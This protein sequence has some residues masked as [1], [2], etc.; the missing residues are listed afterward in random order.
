M[1]VT[2]NPP[3]HRAFHSFRTD[4]L[5]IRTALPTDAPAVYA[6][7]SN[8]ANNP[9]TVVNPDLSPAVFEERIE[10]WSAASSRGE[11][12]FMAIF[13]R[14][15]SNDSN[16]PQSATQSLEGAHDEPLIGF[17]G[18][19]SLYYEHTSN[20]TSGEWEEVLVGDTGV[21]I[22]HGLWRKGY[23]QE[24]FIGTVEYGFAELGCKYME[25]QT[26]VDNV[27]WRNMMVKLG[28]KQ[29]ETRGIGAAGPGKGMEE[30]QWKF[31]QKDWEQRKEKES[32][33]R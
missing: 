31:E 32:S 14:Q 24:A 17:G 19:N 18:F 22:D 7:R 2:D 16:E 25:V 6:L 20:A 4:R 27:P 29:H 15:D 23:G 1:S 28:L 21:M 12:A 9:H 30:W 3:H 33:E 26:G 10:K 13:L 8:P 5:L 11:S